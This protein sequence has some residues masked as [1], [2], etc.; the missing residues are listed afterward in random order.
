MTNKF[1]FIV[2]LILI[3]FVVISFTSN[4]KSKTN[5]SLEKYVNINKD[6]NIIKINLDDYITG[7]V[8]GEMPAEF[9]MEALKAQAVVS[10]TYALYQMEKKNYLNI[11]TN[12]QVYIDID[13]M[14]NK[15]NND[16]DKYY[17]KIKYAVKMTSNEIITY[18]NKPIKS[19]YFAMSNGTTEDSVNVFNEKLDYIKPVEVMYDNNSIKNFEYLNS[20]KKEDIINT[21][22]LNCNNGFNYNIIKDNQ[23]YVSYINICDKSITGTEFRKIFKLRSASFDIENNDDTIIIKNFGYGHGVGMSQYGANGY[24]KNGMSYKDII[25]HFYNKVQIKR[26]NFK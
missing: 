19:Y 8:A 2:V 21:L 23:N 12:D 16:F 15:W 18:K 7:V 5:F 10:R 24:A 26:I 4:K 20:Y 3:P 25:H 1:L 11:D 9:H 13:E 17:K 6:N 22:N 14:K